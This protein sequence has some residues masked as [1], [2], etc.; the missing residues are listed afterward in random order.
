MRWSTALP[1]ICTCSNAINDISVCGPMRATWAP[2]PLYKPN[3]PEYQRVSKTCGGK[4]RRL[5][6]KAPSARN[7]FIIQSVLD[8]YLISFS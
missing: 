7:V 6:V 4:P 2:K 3:G 8:E 5:R 1:K